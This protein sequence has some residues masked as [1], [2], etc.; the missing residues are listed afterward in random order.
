VAE[1]ANGS[2]GGVG[3]S[4]SQGVEDYQES[5]PRNRERLTDDERRRLERE[6]ELIATLICYCPNLTC[7]FAFEKEDGCN[8]VRCKPC[9]LRFCCLCKAEVEK[10]KR[11]YELHFCKHGAEGTKERC[12]LCGLCKKFSQSKKSARKKWEAVASR[13]RELDAGI[14]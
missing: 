4:G 12:D 13:H 3:R 9:G 5:G 6:E 10:G 7:R 8:N 14:A 2:V 1:G 11:G